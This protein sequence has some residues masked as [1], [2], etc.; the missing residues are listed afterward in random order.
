MEFLGVP[1]STPD[2]KRV[3]QLAIQMLA[4][5]F[6]MWADDKSGIM[7]DGGAASFMMGAAGCIMAMAYGATFEHGIRGLLVMWMFGIPLMALADLLKAVL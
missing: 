7:G 6:I 1:L 2:A 4:L 5:I 3:R